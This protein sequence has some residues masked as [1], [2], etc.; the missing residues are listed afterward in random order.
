[1]IVVDRSV[2]VAVVLGEPDAVSYGASLRAEPVSV[3]T[4]SLVESGI[5][6]EARQGREAGRDL[7]ELLRALAATVVPVDQRQADLAIRA[8]RRFGKGRHPAAPNL[9]DCFSYALAQSLDE[10][11]LFKAE[12][13]AQ[14]DIRSARH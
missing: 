13:F 6:V 7:V 9:G 12:D 10:P 3:S 5:V 8:W 14:T 11:L 4:V 2:L 1:M